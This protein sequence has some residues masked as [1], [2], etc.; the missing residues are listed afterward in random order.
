MGVAGSLHRAVPGVTQES[1][2]SAWMCQGLRG[3]G[4]IWKLRK[5]PP[6]PAPQTGCCVASGKLL[7]LSA[8]QFS[9]VTGTH[10][11]LHVPTAGLP[12]PPPVTMS[13]P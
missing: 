10:E 7:N 9:P 5:P 8:P 11:T 2:P 4:R 13:R 3:A 12:P 6:Q 1:F